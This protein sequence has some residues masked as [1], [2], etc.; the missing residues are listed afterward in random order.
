MA[1][2]ILTQESPKVSASTHRLKGW[3]GVLWARFKPRV[4]LTRELN[5]ETG[6]LNF[7]SLMARS[8]A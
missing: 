7:V 4:R 5:T 6:T 1:D 3:S 2:S 8:M